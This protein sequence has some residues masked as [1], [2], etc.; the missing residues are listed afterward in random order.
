MSLLFLLL[1]LLLLLLLGLACICDDSLCGVPAS[2][3]SL[4][5]LTALYSS[6]GLQHAFDS[7]LVGEAVI[8]LCQN[9][10]QCWFIHA[11]CRSVAV[12]AP[13]VCR[14]C[15]AAPLGVSILSTS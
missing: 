4:A 9:S 12:Q 13:A 14:P 10:S 2:M 15:P 1:L 6:M 11:G 3:C 8:A 5:V 7:R